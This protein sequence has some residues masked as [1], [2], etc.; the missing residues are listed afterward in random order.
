ME[1]ELRLANFDDVE[2]VLA[3]HH[4]YQINS[5]SD[6][7]KSDGF[8]TTAFTK[9]NVI[10]LIEDEKGRGFQSPVRHIEF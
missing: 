10:S 3:L 7:D 4:K 1:I 9:E 8:I 5:I 6:E 2:Q